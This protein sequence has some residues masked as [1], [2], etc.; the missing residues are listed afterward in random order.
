MDGLCARGNLLLYLWPNL[1]LPGIGSI[2]ASDLTLELAEVQNV[3][4]LFFFV[5]IFVLAAVLILVFLVDDLLDNAVVGQVGGPRVAL[6]IIL[7]RC[8]SDIALIVGPDG[9]R[10][11]I[12]NKYPLSDVKLARVD[13]Q[14][15]FNVLLNDHPAPAFLDGFDNSIVFAVDGDAATTRPLA[16]LDDPDVVLTV[17]HSLWESFSEHTKG[18]TDIGDSIILI[19]LFFV[20]SDKILHPLILEQF[21]GLRNHLRLRH[22]EDR[23]LIVGD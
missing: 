21:V 9:E 3:V 10:V 17:D 6:R 16:W 2:L 18:L 11:P 7:G 1:L 14:W 13:D 4:I 20:V 15:I 23:P 22:L 8:Q 5:V 19:Y 12:S